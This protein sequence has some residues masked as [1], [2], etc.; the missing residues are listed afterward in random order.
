MNVYSFQCS[1]SNMEFVM[2]FT[3]TY[4]SRLI[5]TPKYSENYDFLGQK[6]II[7][8]PLCYLHIL[9]YTC[10][11]PCYSIFDLLDKKYNNK[12]L[13]NSKEKIIYNK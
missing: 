12:R 1:L 13:Q 7:N 6:E 8:L 2:N 11:Y 5:F 3:Q 10:F 4:V 9:L